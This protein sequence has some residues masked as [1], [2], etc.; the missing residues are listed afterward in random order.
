VGTPRGRHVLI[1]PRRRLRTLA[2]AATALALG[3]AV[4]GAAAVPALAHGPDDG[5]GG[6]HDD[7]GGW[8][9]DN[10]W[11]GDRD[12]D[13][14]DGDR[15]DGDRDGD[16]DGDHDGWGGDKDA[17]PP[18]PQ[19]PAPEPAPPAPEPAPPAPA[20]PAPEPAPP[21]PEPAPP[22]PEPAPEP[23]P[24]PAPAIA[25]AIA[26]LESNT[27]SALGKVPQ[28][29][30]NDTDEKDVAAGVATGVA[31]AAAAGFGALLVR[32]RRDSVS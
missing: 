4:T 19:P 26:P 6:Y 28:A 24:E 17:A 27:M 12:G 22:A 8:D 15:D 18:V 30:T 29:A 31:L 14:Y 16:H 11:G 21:A 9:G 20:P 32:S 23:E 25:T 13:R 5:S 10:A 7:G 2:P 3:V 1:T